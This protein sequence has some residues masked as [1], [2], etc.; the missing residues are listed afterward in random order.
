MNKSQIIVLDPGHGGRDNGAKWG[1][2]HE[3]DINLSIAFYLRY[4][5]MLSSHNNI[6]MTRESD[7]YV[8]LKQRCKIAE[9]YNADIF[10]SIHCDA[11]HNISVSGMG[12]YIHTTSTGDSFTLSH[13][14]GQE[15]ERLFPDHK[16]RDIKHRNFYV[17]RK[18][19]KRTA[20]LVECE[21]LSNPKTRLFLREAENQVQ[22][23]QS[24]KIGIERFNKC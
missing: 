9:Y 1:Y 14:I 20:V 22:L 8:S 3:D 24:I 21:F 13:F 7:K 12:T 17:L 15:M 6:I 19:R 18:N 11:F 2:T 4:E 5:L 23:A 10:L 16:H